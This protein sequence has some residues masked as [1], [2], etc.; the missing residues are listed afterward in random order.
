MVYSATPA[1]AP[2]SSSAAAQPSPATSSPDKASE[3]A[4]LLQ[5]QVRLLNRLTWGATNASAWRLALNGPDDLIADQLKPGPAELPP[6]VQA[7]IDAM[8]VSAAPAHDIVVSLQA[9]QQAVNKAPAGEARE[10]LRR[11]YNARLR[12]LSQEARHRSLLRSIYSQRQLQEKMTWFWVN[13]FN[14]FAEKHAYTRPLMVDFE[15]N[16]IRPHA[17]GK[18]RDLLAATVTHPA[19]LLYLD[20]HQNRRGGLNEN[21]ARELLELHTLGADGGQKQADVVALSRVLTGLGFNATD[22][23]PNLPRGT[24]VEYRRRGVFEFNSARHD[25]EP[26]RL[27]G[28]QIQG[29]NLT[30]VDQVIDMLARHP[31]TAAHVS[32]KL[33]VYFVADD[34]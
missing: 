33:A 13:H 14:V 20:N 16:A 31:S 29:G 17:L 22:T 28:E 1:P 18:F 3:T 27:L 12:L 15:E 23:P 2:K 34:P 5:E 6:D 21:Y 19:M 30:E 26:K 32:R 24:D 9:Q 10:E 8:Q 25:N 4:P 11:A 7:A